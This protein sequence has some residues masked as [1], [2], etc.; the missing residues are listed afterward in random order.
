MKSLKL[1]SVSYP[2]PASASVP[3]V[4]DSAVEAALA[5]LS[6]PPSDGGFGAVVVSETP[7]SP[8]PTRSTGSVDAGA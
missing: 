7:D 6:I 4:M 5:F 3:V 1:L 8:S 2:F